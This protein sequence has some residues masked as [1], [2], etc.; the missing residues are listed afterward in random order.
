MQV[1]SAFFY[2]M[3]G[4]RLQNS[5]LEFSRSKQE[6]KKYEPKNEKLILNLN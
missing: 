3:I 4:I 2:Y 6:N 5:L 1:I